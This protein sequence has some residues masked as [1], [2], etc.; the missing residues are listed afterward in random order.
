MAAFGERMRYMIPENEGKGKVEQRW[1]N[2]IFLGS[3]DESGEALIGT[4]EGVV[5]VRR[6]EG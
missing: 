6:C 4:P 2:G 1:R 5:K 3:R